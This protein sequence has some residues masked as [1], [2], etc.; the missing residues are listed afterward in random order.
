ME[1]DSLFFPDIPPSVGTL[2]H[3]FPVWAIKPLPE[4]DR[5]CASVGKTQHDFFVQ[6]LP[7]IVY[8]VERA[9]KTMAEKGNTLKNPIL[10]VDFLD[11]QPGTFQ[12]NVANLMGCITGMCDMDVELQIEDLQSWTI[13]NGWRRILTTKDHTVM[14]YDERLRRIESCNHPSSL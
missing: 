9:A 1:S 7:G 2:E 8:A 14:T 13:E 5:I 3:P 4:I 10:S 6:L 11:L 12:L